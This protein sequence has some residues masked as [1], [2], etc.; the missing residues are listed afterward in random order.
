M[1][2]ILAAVM[3]LIALLAL[4]ANAESEIK[5][6][7]QADDVLTHFEKIEGAASVACPVGQVCLPK[8]TSR[9]VCVGT[10]SNCGVA[11][12]AQIK[13]PGGFDLLITF[14]LGSDRL[15]DVAKANLKEFAKAI[16]SPK[17]EASTFNVD[18]HTDARG[19][20][21]LNNALSERRAQV[22]IEFLNELGVDT[23]RLTAQGYGETKPRLEEDPFAAINRRVEAT[24][25]TW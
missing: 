9:G 21:S 22:V 6:Q 4:N 20:D 12:P 11:R 8:R 14:E 23:E 24:I 1:T 10:S 13:D 7:F 5:P 16:E 19:A 3:C 18:G 25:R 17:L 2:K 15:S